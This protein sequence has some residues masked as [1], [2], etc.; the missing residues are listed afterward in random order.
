MKKQ[1]TVKGS[2]QPV[3]T[4]KQI[5]WEQFSARLIETI[6]KKKMTRTEFAE[7]VGVT[8][9]SV[10]H[11][12]NDGRIPSAFYLNKMCDVLKVSADYLLGRKKG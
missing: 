1:T 6:E 7:K 11:W 12:L 10:T 5:Y 3:K 2:K 8:C 9:V 4:E